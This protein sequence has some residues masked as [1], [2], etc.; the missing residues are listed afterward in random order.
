M[1]N[2]INQDL[3]FQKVASEANRIY[4]QEWNY[5]PARSVALSLSL[6]AESGDLATFRAAQQ[7]GTENALVVSCKGLVI[8]A[9]A[10]YDTVEITIP[11]AIYT[12]VDES[13]PDGLQIVDLTVAPHY[14][15]GI[16]G[17]VS[18]VT[19]NDEAAYMASV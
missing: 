1:E 17:P 4:P 8:G 15:S 9:T 6:L 10:G 18:I 13:F 14:D 7:A 2:G 16:A 5:T 12:Q 3:A 11:K 19:T